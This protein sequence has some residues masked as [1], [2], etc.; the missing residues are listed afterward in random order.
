MTPHKFT[1]GQKVDFRPQLSDG[2]GSR[3]SYTITR[4]LPGDD[5][6]RTYRA[7]GAQDGQERVLRERQ[8][9]AVPVG[10]FG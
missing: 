3:G 4:I 7:R 9:T 10:V 2:P 5:L 1:I 8:L 6:D